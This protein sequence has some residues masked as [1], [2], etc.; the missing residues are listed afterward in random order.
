MTSKKIGCTFELSFTSHTALSMGCK[1]S[2]PATA[3]LPY[4]L[5]RIVARN[6]STMSSF[7]TFDNALPIFLWAYYEYILKPHGFHEPKKLAPLII[8]LS[9]ITQASALKIADRLVRVVK[10]PQRFFDSLKDLSPSEL[11]GFMAS[12]AIFY[13]LAHNKYISP[14]E[15]NPIDF[16]DVFDNEKDSP[17]GMR[18]ILCSVFKLVDGGIDQASGGKNLSFEV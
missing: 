1:V 16:F 17:E 6:A 4:A 9:N 8:A 5:T 3:G 12:T 11:K 13:Y 7:Q 18:D 10:P 15:P 14:T 2:V